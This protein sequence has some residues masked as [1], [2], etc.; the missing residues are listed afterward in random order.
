[1][2]TNSPPP[3]YYAHPQYH[4]LFS[5]PHHSP[6]IMFLSVPILVQQK[7][8]RLVYLGRECMKMTATSLSI[9]QVWSK[10][11]NGIMYNRL[12]C[13]MLE[14]KR[15]LLHLLCYSFYPLHD[16]N[17]HNANSNSYHSQPLSCAHQRDARLFKDHNQYTESDHLLYIPWHS[18]GIHQ[19]TH[20]IF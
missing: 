7:R 10:M 2:H 18:L 1:M 3:T 4:M 17:H 6:I 12:L 11:A 19:L 8:N 13:S 9:I 5:H 15:L 20:P 14:T 16:G